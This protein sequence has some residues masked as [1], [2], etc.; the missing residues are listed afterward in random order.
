MV[1]NLR[2]S[3]RA[4]IW[5]PVHGHHYAFKGITIHVQEDD[6]HCRWVNLAD[7]R[8]VVGATA[9]DSALVMTYGNK[10]KSFGSPA[11]LHIRDDALVTHLGKENQPTALRFRTWVERN[12]AFPAR[13][14]SQNL[15]I[16]TDACGPGG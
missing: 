10:L 7:V 14:S 12:I 11:Q 16:P 9:G 3:V 1:S 5:L 13:R 15:G 6:D 4:H 8:K 2:R